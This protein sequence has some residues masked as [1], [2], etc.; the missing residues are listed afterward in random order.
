MNGNWYPWSIGSSPSEYVSAWQRIHTMMKQK[1][2]DSTRIQWIWCVNNADVGPYTAE[3]YWV[4]DAY[5]DWL[6]IDGYNFGSSQTWSTWQWPEQVF[7]NMI[8]RVR[9]LSSKPVSINEYASTSKRTG[10]ISNVTSKLDWLNRF[11]NYTNVKQIKMASYFNTDKETD[12]AIFGG[13][14]G[15]TLWNGLK[16]YSS[17]QVCLQ[18]SDWI[19]SDSSNIRLITDLQFSGQGERFFS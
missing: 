4:G 1:G 8:Q 6:G 17:Y 3:N 11:C 16:T 10:A 19:P 12:W 7:D 9:A 13:S 18:T 14:L 2:L 5:V 15:D